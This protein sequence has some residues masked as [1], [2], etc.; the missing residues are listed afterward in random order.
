MTAVKSRGTLVS[1]LITDEQI[2]TFLRGFG[3]LKERG[4]AL[5]L[6]EWLIT[7]DVDRLIAPEDGP[8]VKRGDDPPDFVISGT[9]KK[10]IAVEVSTFVTERKRILDKSPAFPGGYTSTLRR[11]KADTA[12]HAA[13]K[14]GQLPDDSKVRPH[15]ENTADLDNDYYKTMQPVLS[16][17]V[18]DAKH[19][20]GMFGHTVILI[21]DSLSE[22]EGTIERRLP[23]LREYLQ[24][25]Q[26][27]ASVEVVLITVGKR[28]AGKAY[29]L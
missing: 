1:D 29:R 26:P 19:Y 17:K 3:D 21:E 8:I 28:R 12:F 13:I 16:K 27:P 22:F 18:A 15:F 10:T 24:S 25:L 11:G 9:K 20:A 14:K 2:N 6:M 4:E 23:Q 5:V 7:N